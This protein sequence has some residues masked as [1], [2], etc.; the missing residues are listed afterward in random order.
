MLIIISYDFMHCICGT[1]N[2]TRVLNAARQLWYWGRGS[3]KLRGGRKPVAV[4]Q[5]LGWSTIICDEAV[6]WALVN[7]PPRC[8]KKLWM[9]TFYRNQHYFHQKEGRFSH[10]I[11]IPLRLVCAYL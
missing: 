1:S 4:V 8:K 10:E 6:D 5:L 2:D 7:V 11:S 9:H 3:G